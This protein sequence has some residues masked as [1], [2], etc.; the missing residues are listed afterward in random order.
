MPFRKIKYFLEGKESYVYYNMIRA[1]LWMML[2]PSLYLN[3]KKSTNGRIHARVRE[4]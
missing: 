1:R 4:L 3:F 2:N